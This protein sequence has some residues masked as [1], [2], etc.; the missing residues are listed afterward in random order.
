V[1]R[2]RHRFLRG[3]RLS[4]GVFLFL[5]V[6]LEAAFRF[7]APVEHRARASADW[8]DQGLEVHRPSSVAGLEYLH[9]ER[10]A[11]PDLHWP[12][13]VQGFAEIDQATRAGRIPVVLAILPLLDSRSWRGYPLWPIH[14]KVAAQGALHG[15]RVLDLGRRMAE[16]KIP[17]RTILLG[18]GIHATVA[19]NR[20]FAEELQDFL[21]RELL[22][23][24]LRGGR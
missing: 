10:A 7:L 17:P 16:R 14:E 1:G 3:L 8:A 11:W 18:D 21:E 12:N 6:L 4:L 5:L 23:E 24:R 2:A 19:G 15:F 20:L 22:Q 9:D 13:V